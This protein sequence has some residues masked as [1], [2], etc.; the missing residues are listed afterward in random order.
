M[1]T[2]ASQCVHSC[3]VVSVVLAR[4]HLDLIAGDALRARQVLLQQHRHCRLHAGASPSDQGGCMWGHAGKVASGQNR[5]PCKVL[6][7]G[8]L[9]S[10]PHLE[11]QAA[12]IARGERH[13]SGLLWLGK[14]LAG[15]QRALP[16]ALRH[17]PARV[18]RTVRRGQPDTLLTASTPEMKR[19]QPAKTKEPA[20]ALSQAAPC[21]G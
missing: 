18:T 4:A 3:S 6:H 13:H 20:R 14:D 21:E 11:G 2:H 9:G 19:A 12:E 16:R 17:L 15:L 1:Q 8:V 7:A 5:A 10:R